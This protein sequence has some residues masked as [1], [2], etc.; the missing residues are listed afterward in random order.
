MGIK[1]ANGK[2]FAT[3]SRLNLGFYY[4]LLAAPPVLFFMVSPGL[5]LLGL[6]LT[7]FFYLM[8]GTGARLA[9]YSNKLVSAG[10]I[11]I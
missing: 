5:S 7:L 4:T 1:L 8:M 2:I 11:K 3:N 9:K 10:A 6:P